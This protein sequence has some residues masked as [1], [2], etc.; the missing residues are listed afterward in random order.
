VLLPAA[1]PPRKRKSF[2]IE[3]AD[4]LLHVGIPQDPR[5]ALWMTGLMCGLRPGELAGLRWPYVDIDGDAPCIDVVERVHEIEHRY[6][7]Q[8]AP[9]TARKGAIG[10]HP[11]VVR[12]A[13][14]APQRHDHA[15]AL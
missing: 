3:E 11:L 4:K 1:R 12:G 8:A 14:S 5:P 6:V 2:T 13:A 7:G 15:R 9:K 10:L